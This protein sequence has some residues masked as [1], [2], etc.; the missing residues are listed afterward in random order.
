[1]PATPNQTLNAMGWLV[2]TPD[3]VWEGCRLAAGVNHR[4]NWGRFALLGTG[5]PTLMRGPSRVFRARFGALVTVPDEYQGQGWGRSMS[6]YLDLSREC[7]D[8]DLVII[9]PELLAWTFADGTSMSDWQA[10]R[11]VETG[12]SKPEPA[13]APIP[14]PAPATVP[15]PTP[16][17]DPESRA[18]DKWN[19]GADEHNQWQELGQD[20]RDALIEA[21]TQEK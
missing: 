20:E 3:L 13:P 17:S 9:D 18:K 14:E 8:A 2:T 1:M 15:E 16:D 11:V 10:R 7:T 19:K 6:V 12:R 21:E 4:Q 5:V